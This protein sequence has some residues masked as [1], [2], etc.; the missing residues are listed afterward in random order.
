M[1]ALEGIENFELPK[2]LVTRIAKSAVS[3][4]FTL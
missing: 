2:A 1:F 4:V 3:A